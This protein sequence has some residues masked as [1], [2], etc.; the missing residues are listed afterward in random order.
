MIGSGIFLLPAT[1]AAFGGIS[2]IGWL[3]SSLGAL[4]LAITFGH[5]GK[6]APNTIGGPYA[7]TRLG[8]GNFLGYL[9]AWGYWVSIWCTNA[10]IAVAFVGYLQVFLPFLKT[11]TPAAI[12]CGLGVIWLFTWINSKPLKTIAAV[13]RITTILKLT[14]ILCVGFIGIFYINLDHFTVFNS[15]NETNFGA[16]TITTTATLFAFLGMESASIASANTKNAEKTIQRA[17]ITGTLITIVAY[18][19]SSV[20]IMGIIPMETLAHSNAPFADAATLF[21]GSAAGYIV[22]AGAIIATLGALNGWIL[23]QGKI[24]MAAAQ[25]QLFP[26]LF[27]KTN[28]NNAPLLGIVLSSVLASVVMGLRF[29]ESLVNTFTFMMNLSTLS[30]LTPYLLSALSLILL[31]KTKKSPSNTKK[32]ITAVAA[33]IFCVW[34]IFGSGFEV[35]IWGTLLLFIGIPFY[36]GINKDS[37]KY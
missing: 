35:I 24:P 34:V 32:I 8:L 33:M 3:C 25:D 18:I 5:L 10:A 20:A 36:F 37:K 26:R 4:L 2:L 14:P 11:N 13:Q 27:K 28:K 29:S 7:Y 6:I 23:I 30:V 16:I 17:T 1:L 9:V 12:S 15:S 22:A 21:W 19:L 31:L